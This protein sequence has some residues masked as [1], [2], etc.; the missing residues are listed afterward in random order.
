[1]RVRTL[2]VLTACAMALGCPSEPSSPTEPTDATPTPTNPV[3]P[4]PTGDPGQT[5][6]VEPEEGTS[7]GRCPLDQ[8]VGGFVVDEQSDP[9]I[10]FTSVAGVVAD[11]VLPLD[12]MN[13]VVSEGDC[14]LLQRP[15]LF[16]DPPCAAGETC[17][18]DTCVPYPSNIDAGRVF[19]SGMDECVDMSPVP[20]GSNYFFNGLPH[21]GMAPG[22]LIQLDTPDFSLHA[23]GVDPLT[24]PDGDWVLVQGQ[25]LTVTWTAASVPGSRIDISMAIDQ[26]G[27]SP[28]ALECSFD[29]DGEGTVPA[30]IVDA[31]INSGVSG[32]PAGLMVRQT[33]DHATTDAGCVDFVVSST[34]PHGLDVDGFTPCNS[35][36]E[37][38]EPQV[39]DVPNQICV[40]P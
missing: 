15:I 25:D 35:T 31:F 23:R 19:I 34:R 22:D 33:S 24:F 2:A 20:P 40:D 1:M 10:S 4:T 39:C 14:V 29:D 28:L 17:D 27:A 30:S 26:H 32:F 7:D 3:T 12:V 16:C 11:S 21:P 5:D 38:P 13:T 8:R 9:D 36:P 6:C 18:G 37:C